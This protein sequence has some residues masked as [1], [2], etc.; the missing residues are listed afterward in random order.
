MSGVGLWILSDFRE[1]SPTKGK[2][3]GLIIGTKKPEEDFGLP[4][5]VLEDGSLPRLRVPAGIYHAISP[6]TDERL[7]VSALGS[8][9]FVKEDYAYPALNEVP[10]AREL[11]TRCGITIE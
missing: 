9:A 6:L 8:T 5:F 2:T 7:L 4:C 11:L 1:T 10:D 3:I